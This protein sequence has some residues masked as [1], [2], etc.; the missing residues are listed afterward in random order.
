MTDVAQ[1][2]MPERV[3]Q[4]RHGMP[5]R[6]DVTALDERPRLALGALDELDGRE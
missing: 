1:P 3:S 6:N 2:R 5:H 4:T